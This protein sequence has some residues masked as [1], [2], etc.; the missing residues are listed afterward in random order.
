MPGNTE[1][2]VTESGNPGSRDAVL[3]QADGPVAVLTINRPAARLLQATPRGAEM[4][5]KVAMA[6]DAVIDDRLAAIRPA[7]RA[8]FHAV[9]W[10]IVTGDAPQR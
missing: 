4:V 9:L 2:P 3:C 1:N 6:R 7:D 10:S 8:T 5:N